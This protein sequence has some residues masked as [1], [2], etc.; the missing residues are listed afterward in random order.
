MESRPLQQDIIYGPINS[1]R[2]G[3]SLGVNILPTRHKVCSFDCLYCQYGFTPAQQERWHVDMEELPA[4]GKV[5]MALMEALPGRPEI[6]AITLA[7]NGEPTLHPQ[8]RKIC[9]VVVR[10]RDMYCK[11]VPVCILSNSS[12]VGSTEVRA[13]LRLLEHPIMKLDAGTQKTFERINRPRPGVKLAKILDG[14]GK[15]E[16]LEIQSLFLGGPA[17]NATDSEVSAWLGHLG[18]LRPEA[19]QLYTFDRR[20]ADSALQPVSSARLREISE[21]VKERLPAAKVQI[22]LPDNHR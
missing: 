1:R 4:P 6:D 2:L 15:L 7:G 5:A 21:L 17:D 8:F 14:L 3:V 13:G 18:T 11:G 9:E 22:F 10:Q 19:V 20:P 16:H 12:T